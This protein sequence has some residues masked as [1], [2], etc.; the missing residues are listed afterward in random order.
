MKLF[1]NMIFW[2]FAAAYLP[3]F[4]LRL[5][6]EKDK[7]RLLAERL[8][9]HSREFLMSLEGKRVLWVHAVSVGEVFAARPL[10]DE[11][12]LS[13]PDWAL[14]VSTVTPTGQALARKLFDPNRVFYFP[15]D[16]SGCVRRTFSQLMP[17][18]VLLMETEIWPNLIL[19]A[20][21]RKIPVGIV[22]GRLSPRSYE[23]YRWVRWLFR[24]I[25]EKIRFF[26]VQFQ[27]DADRLQELGVPESVICISGNM[28]FDTIGEGSEKEV[29]RLREKFFPQGEAGKILLAGSTH[30]GEEEILLGVFRK[31]RFE[32]P[33]L[34]L[35]LAPRHVTRSKKLRQCV[36]DHHFRCRFVSEGTDSAGQDVW[37][38]DTMGDLKKWYGL[39]DFVFVGGSLV[40]HGGQNPIEAA[41][42]KKPILFGPHTF[43]FQVI[44]EAL[45]RERAGYQVYNA[46]ELYEF[47]RSMLLDP[48]DSGRAGV[49][50]YEIVQ[51]FRGAASKNA[52]FVRRFLG[53]ASPSAVREA[54]GT[55]P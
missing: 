24:G 5:R 21:D 42:W 3:F 1:Y 8:G 44:Y 49:K 22:N 45:M 43:N 23:H 16:T 48:Y 2:V 15:F 6:Q 53:V 17:E 9:Y 11:L 47:L 41:I 29:A 31:L 46:A 36:E 28:K 25:L 39:A 50:A 27:W 10:I 40:T 38:L 26:L 20:W 33:D 12:A 7:K 32:F 18:L 52:D 54:V 37:V 35:V 4:L 34:K 14:V 55:S 30:E 51:R 13:L 19:G